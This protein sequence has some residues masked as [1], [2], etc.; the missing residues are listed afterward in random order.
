M[1]TYGYVRVSTDEQALSVEAQSA[2]ILARH[3]DALI[4]TDVGVSG[5]TPLSERPGFST[6][7][8]A[9][10][11]TLVAIRLD[12]IA[13]STVEAATLLDRFSAEGVNLVLFDLGLDLSTPTG[14]LVYDV[15]AAVAAFERAMIAERTK[16]ALQAKRD[17][18]VEELIASFPLS[19]SSHGVARIL[20]EEHGIVVSPSTIQR[21][22]RAA[23]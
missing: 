4:V 19:V 17:P 23:V 12:R 2:A 20:A 7:D 11:D 10:G 1:T 22:R 3:P 5:A 8:F 18:E 21:R 16:E 14:R 9:P 6:I 13:R 15:L